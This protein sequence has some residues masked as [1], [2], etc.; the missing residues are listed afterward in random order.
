[1]FY[2]YVHTRND[3]NKVFYIGKGSGKRAFS[4]YGRNNYWGKVANKHGFTGSIVAEWNTEK[5]ALNHEIFLISCFK[6]MNYELVNMT[7]GGENPPSKKGLTGNRSHMFGR[8][9]TEATKTKM[10]LKQAGESNGFFGKKH[11]EETLKKISATSLGRC[12]GRKNTQ[13][14]S[15][16]LA[17]N[18]ETGEQLL[19]C[20]AKEL[21]A[22]GFVHGKVYQCLNGKRK[23]HKG[24]T[25]KRVYGT[26]PPL[27]D[28][29]A[30]PT[31]EQ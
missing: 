15:E 29:A 18:V 21:N 30:N 25:F 22:F 9:L 6:D 14:I 31:K 13:F 17:I 4:G 26:V 11:S 8:K 12:L 20:G 5:E 1:M 19:F 10:S 23:T 3:T 27:V 2:T 16:I 7:D 28:L 24:Y